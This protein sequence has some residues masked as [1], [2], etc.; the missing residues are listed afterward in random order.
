M[1]TFSGYVFLGMMGIKFFFR[2]S[3]IEKLRSFWEKWEFE[4]WSGD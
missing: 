1:V 3:G 2:V 4:G